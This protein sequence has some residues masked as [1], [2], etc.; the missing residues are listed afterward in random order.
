MKLLLAATA[1]LAL[2]LPAA[3]RAQVPFAALARDYFPL[4]AQARA[5]SQWADPPVAIR[6]WFQSLMPPDNPTVSCRGK[7]D[8]FE[9]D[10]FESG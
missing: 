2:L 6:Q 4:V 10:V 8:A 9:A 3:A 5:G 1:G 7:A